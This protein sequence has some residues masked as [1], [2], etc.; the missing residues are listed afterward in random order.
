MLLLLHQQ[1][2][3]LLSQQKGPLCFY[4]E[5]HSAAV[6]NNFKF[7]SRHKVLFPVHNDTFESCDTQLSGCT[8]FELVSVKVNI[9][10]VF[11]SYA[12]PPTLSH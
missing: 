11:T 2:L 6:Y 8:R 12:L 3:Y 10:P 5:K 9:T 7:D 1:E 4:K